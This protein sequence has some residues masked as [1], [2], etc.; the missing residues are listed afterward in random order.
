MDSA[1]AEIASLSEEVARLKL[2]LQNKSK[3]EILISRQLCL[4][5]SRL[6]EDGQLKYLEKA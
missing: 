4:L 2:E 6:L 1:K 5:R 3:D